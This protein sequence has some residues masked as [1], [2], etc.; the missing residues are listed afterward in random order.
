M[1]VLLDEILSE[2]GFSAKEI[3][4]I[5]SGELIYGG[6]LDA[7]SDK[8]LSVKLGFHVKAKLEN[9][10]ELFMHF[11]KKKEFDPTVEELGMI[12]EDG[13]DGCLEDFAGVRLEPNG[14]AMMKLYSAAKPGSD[15]N[16][17]KDEIEKFKKLSKGATHSDIENCLRQILL[18]RFR[19]YKKNGLAGIQPYARSKKEFLPGGELKQQIEVGPILKKY[20]P[21]FYK[22]AIE[23]P[24]N[25]PE[26]AEE[27]FFW[28][29]SIIDEKPTIGE[30][31]SVLVLGHYLINVAI[32]NSIGNFNGLFFF[33]FNLK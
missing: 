4:K 32:F 14:A 17:S 24:Q 29:N 19:S 12:A 20:S 9:V 21:V 2:A 10:K 23:Y 8:E 22:Y 30:L 13:G 16:L 31:K 1:T 11:P 28:V 33:N 25:K 3:E 6:S 15:L 18:D 27:S 7:A 5:R 26:G